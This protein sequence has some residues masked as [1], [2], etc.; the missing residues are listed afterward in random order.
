MK[1][2]SWTYLF[3]AAGL[4]IVWVYCLK[5]MELKKIASIG[6]SGMLSNKQSM[7]LLIPVIGYAVTGVGNIIFFYLAMKQIPTSVAFAAWMA[8]TLSGVKVIDTIVFKENIS[9][10]QYICFAM[11]I[12]GI[13][14]LKKTF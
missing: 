1:L 3:I 6:F 10:I 7:L 2:L 9:I 13:I 8:I 11:I 4:E 5:F 14:G 12:L